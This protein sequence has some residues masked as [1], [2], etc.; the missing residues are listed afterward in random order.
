MGVLVE[1]DINLLVSDHTGSNLLQNG[2]F[3]QDEIKLYN[4]VN[5]EKQVIYSPSQDSPRNFFIYNFES[6]G[7]YNG[8]NLIRIFPNLVDQST[9]T[10]TLIEW[11]ETDIDTIKTEIDRKNRSATFVTSIWINNQLKWN[12]QIGKQQYESGE[13]T[14]VS[15]FIKLIK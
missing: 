3:K 1:T 9:I 14:M 15:R 10:T 5:G 2:K 11:N 13:M 7:T 8:Q 6:P 4:I 12:L